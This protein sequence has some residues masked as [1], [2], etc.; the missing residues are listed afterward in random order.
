M[1]A[2][3]QLE[4]ELKDQPHMPLKPHQVENLREE[5]DRLEEAVNAPKWVENVRRGD[6]AK[7]LKKVD[8][9]L[10]EQ[11]PKPLTGEK[12]DRVARLAREVED[13]I[14]STM[15]SDVVMR[16]NPS[17]SVGRYQRGEGSAATKSAILTWRRAL[18]ALDPA[19]TDPDYTSIERLR[20]TGLNVNGTSTFMADAQIP[21]VFAMSPQAKDNWPAGMPPQGTVNSPLV[22]AQK[23]EVSEKR[24][25]ALAKAR[26]ARAAKR[27]TA[28][29]QSP[30]TP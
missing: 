13:H 29:S 17:G 16:R 8:K 6:A 20:P 11:S 30:P 5:R 12:K 25:A 9:T 10:N 24:K 1:S 27:A 28:E 18:R 21:G 19:N 7:M 15:Q 23:A 22:Q 3:N 4:Q 2:I 14:R 26:A